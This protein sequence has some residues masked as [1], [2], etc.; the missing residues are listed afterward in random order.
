MSIKCRDLIHIQKKFS[1]KGFI[2]FLNLID[3]SVCKVI[4][5]NSFYNKERASITLDILI[6]LDMNI[7]LILLRK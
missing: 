6:L 3:T 1:N 4:K 2:I 7:F 5:A